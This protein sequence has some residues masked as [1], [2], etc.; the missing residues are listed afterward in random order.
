MTT[1]TRV[2]PPT[3]MRPLELAAAQ[4][5]LPSGLRV[6]AATRGGVPMAEVRLLIPL[7]GGDPLHAATV[8]LL[9]ATLL[10]GT[11][12]C[13]R[14]ALD[15]ELAA[16]GATL[17]ATVRPEHL[18][19]S[20][21]VLA[22]G[23]PR[24]VQLLAEVLTGATYPVPDV[25]PQRAR[26][27]H[28]LRMHAAQ[29]QVI[30]RQVLLRRYF[31]DHPAAREVPREEDLARVE[32]ADLR[33]V[34]ETRL[35]PRGAALVLVG[36]LDPYQA[37]ETAAKAMDGWRHERSVTKLDTPRPGAPGGVETL[38]DPGARQV[39]VGLAGAVPM[40]DFTPHPAAHLA[41]LVFGGY[42]ASRLFE[43]LRE[44]LG[45]VYS[46]RSAILQRADVAVM[47]LEFATD[48]DHAADA[49]RETHAELSRITRTDPPRAAEIE[50][51]RGFAIGSQAVT[52][53]TQGG[54]ADALAMIALRGQPLSWHTRWAASIAA[55]PDRQVR[56]HAAR[57]FDP[58]ALTGFVRGPAGVLAGAPS[59]LGGRL[60]PAT[61]ES[62]PDAPPGPAEQGP[63]HIP[64]FGGSHD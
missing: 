38:D 6:L 40:A 1:Q 14:G 5:T 57:L 19:V 26:L 29:P 16:I 36:D 9:A 2:P 28:R 8:E 48:P 17:S 4:A 30:A 41:N 52:L 56:E 62:R 60:R 54:L 37:I 63:V 31:G 27:L 18:T 53:A 33:R 49:L 24:L 39:M 12:R 25:E 50:A 45:Y 55:V 3:A 44:N 51:A 43:N 15:T 64:E 61:G 11:G 21:Y 35:V 42:F 58:A 20:G 46:C 22:E 23:V 32:A 34:H 47:L 7:G 10:G 59:P 13:D